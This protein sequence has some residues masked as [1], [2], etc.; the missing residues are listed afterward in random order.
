MKKVLLITNRA[1]DE[2]G[3]RAEKID[4][5]TRLLTEENWEVVIGHV[6]KPYLRS[7]LP[8]IFR[9]W[10]LARR[11]NVDVIN[12]I[13]NPLH[14]QVI[15]LIVSLLARIPWVAE[16]RDPMVNN[17]DREAGSLVTKLAKIVEKTTVS[18][19]DRVVWMDGIQMKKEYFTETYPH[20]SEEKFHEL[21]FLGF[22]KSVFEEA[23]TTAYEDF[24]ITYAGSF[25]EGWIEPYNFL[26]G[27]EQYVEQYG[28]D[29][30]IQFYGD[31]N[32]EYQRAVEARDLEEIVYTHEFVPHEE[33]IPVLKGS[34][35]T[36]FIASADPANKL[37]VPSKIW[38]YI[39]S[40]NPILVIG[41]PSFRIQHVVND[42]GLGTVVHPDNPGG[43][44]DAIHA[45]RTGD[46]EYS[47]NAEIFDQFSRRR[48]ITEFAS[49]LDEVSTAD[50]G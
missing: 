17:P 34:D 12:S 8:S 16:F 23:Q 43:I 25:Y 19:A 33:I 45:F 2:T 7:F 46:S 49:Q 29:L 26:D 13:S 28:R 20:I 38:D 32:D 50:D 11:E 6:P 30:R 21:P 15:G 10:K 5:R 35:V 1:P 37:S 36:L 14:L 44:A 27:L 18:V 41:D 47:P 31:W 39:A 9:C 4:T 42:N 3:G 24:T 22:E 48:F 40:R